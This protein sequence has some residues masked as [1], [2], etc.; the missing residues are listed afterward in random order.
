MA[1]SRRIA[2][3]KRP[4]QRRA[5]VTVDAIL[6]AATYILVKAGW[7][8]FTTNSVAERAGVNIAS[9]YQYFPNKE[10]IVAELQRRHRSKA[11]EASP[12]LLQTWQRTRD[13]RGR[14][15][16]L[17]DAA[18]REHQRDP[19]LHRVFSDELPRSARRHDA[20]DEEREMHVWRTLVQPFL[21]NVP[22]PD[23]AIFV[24]RAASHAVIHDAV[25]DRPELL[26]HPLFVDEVTTLLAG[27]LGRRS[28][29][30]RA[31]SRFAQADRRVDPRRTTGR[32]IGREGAAREHAARDQQQRPQIVSRD[33]EEEA[34][35]QP[36]RRQ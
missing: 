6:E 35:Q 2:P 4:V 18:V 25:S 31:A 7:E 13:L 29:A 1:T 19:E 10:A 16:F 24:C 26:Q 15:R 9:L 11:A 22:D 8:R 33:A 34:G 14:L 5:R 23:L 28:R 12:E 36:R 27:Y 17:V 21:G 30:N 32:Q 3:R 20:A